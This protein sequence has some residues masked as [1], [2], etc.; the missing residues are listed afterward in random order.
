ML[1]SRTELAN[2]WL[3]LH[4][5]SFSSKG[6]HVQEDSPLVQGRRLWPVFLG[7]ARE[8]LK[9]LQIVPKNVFF[10]LGRTNG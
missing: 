7:A 4:G 6:R 2:M 8:D 1:F 9:A 5:M 3:G 10:F